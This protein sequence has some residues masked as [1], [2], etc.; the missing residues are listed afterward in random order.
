MPKSQLDRS[1]ETLKSK[2]L[3]ETP[4]IEKM[5]LHAIRSTDA[6]PRVNFDWLEALL[7][8]RFAAAC[9]ALVLLSSV[10]VTSLSSTARQ[11]ADNYPNSAALALGFD[12]FQ[13][14]EL[15]ALS[16]PSRW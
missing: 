10:A 13:A 16:E 8:P 11:K 7:A 12:T 15:L 1:L 9:F 2:P 5:V 14:T 3:P 6:K 4:D